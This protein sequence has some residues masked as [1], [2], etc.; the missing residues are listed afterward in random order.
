MAL[1]T[2]SRVVLF[3]SD[4][5]LEEGFDRVKQQALYWVF[6]DGDVGPSYEA[7]L[8]VSACQKDFFDKLNARAKIARASDR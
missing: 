1:K 4:R 3:S 2:N 7:A 8:P 6:E 5:A